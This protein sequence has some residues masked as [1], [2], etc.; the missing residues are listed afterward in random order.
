MKALFVVLSIIK[1]IFTVLLCLLAFLL[2]AV[3]YLICAPFYYNFSVS[4]NSKT[5][6]K[7]KVSTFLRTI[8]ISGDSS[9]ENP[10][11]LRIFWIF[12]KKI[13][14]GG[15]EP[16]KAAKNANEEI[17][18]EISDVKSTKERA[19]ESTDSADSESKQKKSDKK[20]VKS[21]KEKSRKNQG[22]LKSSLDKLKDFKSFPNKK[23]ILKSTIKLFKELISV[24]KPKE[25]KVKC[26]FGMSNPF[27]TGIILATISTIKPFFN[28]HNISAEADFENKIF[29]IDINAKGWF[30]LLSIILPIIRYLRTKPIWKIVKMSLFSQKKG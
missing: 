18:E 14:I 27:D 2:L 30:N 1:I 10:L 5:E 11:T 25:L 29:E 23:E 13:N 4:H 6:Y 3:S 28:A 9:K 19:K 22:W 7:F 20:A 16:D 24:I 17:N 21:K 15:N 8:I 26:R 12:R